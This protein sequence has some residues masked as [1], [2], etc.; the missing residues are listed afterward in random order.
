[1]GGPRARTAKKKN[2][3]A[4]K[5]ACPACSAERREQ[6]RGALVLWKSSTRTA[7]SLAGTPRNAPS[8]TLVDGVK[9]DDARASEAKRDS[10]AA[11]PGDDAVEA[12]LKPLKELARDGRR[13]QCEVRQHDE[14]VYLLV[15]TVRRRV[16]RVDE[17]R[18]APHQITVFTRHLPVLGQRRGRRGTD[19]TGAWR[20]R[21]RRHE[22]RGR[23][24]GRGV[25]RRRR[26]QGRVLRRHDGTGPVGRRDG[27][28]AA[29]AEST[30]RLMLRVKDGQCP[31][32]EPRT[33]NGTGPFR[34]ERL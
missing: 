14:A 28:A 6:L 34:K 22:G 4:R 2:I 30:A 3:A 16:R 24:G 9:G 26:G 8:L 25:L 19:G 33:I 21:R 10:A 7:A 1:M 20:D 17:R 31:A 15:A 13:T 18:P 29:R 23:G 11:T 32:L 5:R 12:L 27:G